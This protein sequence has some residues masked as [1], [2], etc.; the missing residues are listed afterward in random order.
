MFCTLPALAD[1]PPWYCQV[2]TPAGP[3]QPNHTFNGYSFSLRILSQILHTGYVI[4]G[5]LAATTQG[6]TMSG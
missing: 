2:I 4:L 5:E 1:L 3:G 6:L